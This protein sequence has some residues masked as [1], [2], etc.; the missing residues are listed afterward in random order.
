MWKKQLINHLRELN[1][2]R[3]AKTSA[4]PEITLRKILSR[5]VMLFR[6]IFFK[7]IPT[8]IDSLHWVFN[9]VDIK[10][11]KKC[12][13]W[14]ANNKINPENDRVK[15]KHTKH[16]ARDFVQTTIVFLE[17]EYRNI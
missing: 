12:I 5:N 11:L 6:H 13:V 1:T 15:S 10:G 7:N 4:Y 2:N 16:H 9:S 8:S 17:I 14:I 3:L